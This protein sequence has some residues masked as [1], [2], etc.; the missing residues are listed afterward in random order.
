VVA[1]P[2]AVVSGEIVPHWA[3]EHETDQVT[4]LF[5]GS[6]DTVAVTC[7][8]A[9]TCIR[10]T[11]DVTEIMIGRI[12]ALTVIVAEA[13]FDVSETELAVILTVKPPVG[14]LGGAVNVVATPLAVEVGETEPHGALGQVTL[15][16][17][18]MFVES[19]LTTA[20]ILS[21]APSDT[22]GE[23]AETETLMTGGGGKI[24]PPPHP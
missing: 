1:T 18:P 9:A 13:D 5:A 2:L 10:P 6:L 16:D 20:V 14:A 19:L 17:T 22:I 11:V 21:V 24:G 3:A 8:V 23:A 12:A 7:E 15:H 4:P